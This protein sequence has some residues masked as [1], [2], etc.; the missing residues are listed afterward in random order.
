MHIIINADNKNS[1]IRV[2]V[3]IRML[4]II[5]NITLK[6]EES[7]ILKGDTTFANELLILL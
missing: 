7:Y 1:L 3:R 5:K 6:K 4:H 2:F